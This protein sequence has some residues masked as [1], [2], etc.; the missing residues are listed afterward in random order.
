MILRENWLD[1]REHLDYR[2]TVQQDKR[3]TLQTRAS[4]LH[5]LLYWADDRAF[6]RAPEIRPAYPEF[7]A[8]Q[9]R[10]ESPLAYGTQECSLSMAK[11]FFRWAMAA[12]PRRYRRVTS[13]W[14]DSL[15]PARAQG[16]VARHQ[17]YRLEDV[18]AILAVDD[19]RLHARRIKAAVAMLFLSGAR[20]GA[21]VTLP[22]LAVDLEHRQLRQWT[23]LGVRTKFDKSATTDLMVVPDLWDVVATWD[24]LVRSELE[25]D[26]MWYPNITGAREK[27]VEGTT[28]QSP[29]RSRSFYAGLKRLCAR[30]GV[31]YLSP[32]KLR[33]GFATHLLARAENPGDWKAISQT[34]MHND[35]SVMDRVYGILDD[36][37]VASRIQRMGVAR[38]P[39]ASP[40]PR[41]RPGDRELSQAEIL[42]QIQALMAQLQGRM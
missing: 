6:T 23:D 40:T 42:A 31:T 18:R 22:I 10:D 29:Y 1:I 20:I 19:D 37:E 13:L 39:A 16:H 12:H 36:T 28:L 4:A 30:A 27:R 21:F 11:V 2:E 33:H 5:L 3:R 8:R 38:S 26:E 32:H 9:R 15:R 41:L 25:P 34:L 35:L 14:L 7:L 24:G 17:A